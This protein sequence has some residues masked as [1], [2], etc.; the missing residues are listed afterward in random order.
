MGLSVGTGGLAFAVADGSDPEYLDALTEQLR[1]LSELLVREGLAPHNEPRT[2]GPA[3]GRA[4]TD[5][6]PYSFVHY[7]RRAYA[8]AREYPEQPLTPVAEGDSAADDSVIDLV[9]STFDSHLVCHSDCEGFYV[10]VDFDEVLFVG[11]DV[12]IAGGMV[13]SSTA[14]MRELVYVAPYLGIALVDGMLSDLEIGR[15][16]KMLDSDSS[17]PFDRELITWLLFFEAARVSI[18][19]GTVVEFG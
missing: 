14:L 9:G 6:V 15:I 5:S 18:E 16:Q 11:E 4:R 13:G 2:A 7:L 19:N 3:V 8:L 10:P 1:A 12:D 17:H